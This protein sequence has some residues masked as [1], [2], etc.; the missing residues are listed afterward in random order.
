MVFGMLYAAHGEFAV[1]YEQ[2]FAEKRIILTE[3]LKAQ[4]IRKRKDYLRDLR[5]YNDEVSFYKKVKLAID[6]QD[7][8]SAYYLLLQRDDGE[9]EG[10]D[11]EEL[12]EI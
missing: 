11:I 7:G 2:I 1:T 5:E 9:Y 6:L 4:E 8:Q 3:N 10:F 12:E